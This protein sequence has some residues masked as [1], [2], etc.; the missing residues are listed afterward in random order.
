MTTLPSLNLVIVG[1]VDHGKST[2][3][4]RLLHD[5][6]SLDPSQIE[7]VTERSRQLGRDLEYA[8]FLD[9]LEEEQS[10]NIT[11]DTTRIHLTTPKRVLTIIDA[12]GHKEFLRNMISGA[13]E[14]DAAVLIVD[15]HDGIREQTRRH[16]A[17]L[18]LLGLDQI[19]VAVNKMD[20]VDWSATRFETIRREIKNTLRELNLTPT[21]IVPISARD[22]ANLLD[23]TK[24][25][26][27]VEGP[28]LLD[29]LDRL[30]SPQE[31]QGESPRF[32]VQDILTRVGKRVAVGTLTGGTLNVG[33]SIRLEP[34]GARSSIAGLTRAGKPVSTLENGASG[35]V[36][37]AD[38]VWADRGAVIVSEAET[39][40]A[41]SRLTA[42]LFWFDRAPLTR[43][44]SVT[45]KLGT[46]DT[47]AIVDNIEDVVDAS[48]LDR[49]SGAATSLPRDDTARVS[50]TLDT[51]QFA[52][53]HH[54]HPET[55]RLVITR[56]GRIVGGGTLLDPNTS[57]RS[58]SSLW[59][60]VR[61][62]LRQTTPVLVTSF[63]SLAEGEDFLEGV[64]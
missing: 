49:Q 19:V 63:A 57:N 8:F 7:A 51:P 2:L 61:G 55:G 42:Q 1:H 52:D 39:L 27:W 24:R 18:G 14:A 10:Q 62:W 48:T 29:Q 3:I 35:G 22:G 54:R 44:E 33:D 32:L 45:V 5:T 16:A 25:P 21:A 36:L 37:F 50:L 20:R 26:D 4:G 64:S 34:S 56:R 41:T 15:A 40:T 53:S 46:A 60:R 12:P 47:T 30:Q 28:P 31:V 43:G 17:L 38:D 58:R 59:H 23:G 11:I 13:A 6:G 9:A